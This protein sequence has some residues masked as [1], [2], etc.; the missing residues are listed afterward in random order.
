MTDDADNTD[1]GGSGDTNELDRLRAENARLK[2]AL[3][4]SPK[5]DAEAQAAKARKRRRLG[6]ISF[7]V[8]LAL[9]LPPAVA[10]VWVRNRLLNTDIYVETV[11]PLAND[12][13]IQDAVA[14]R[15]ATE[16]SKAIDLKSVTQ[17]LLPEEAA[18][19]AGVIA[20]GGDNLI[21]DLSHKAVESDQFAEIWA[22]A[23]R[24]AHDALVPLLTGGEG[25]VA[26]F[27]DGKVVVELDKL[28]D[29]V[30]S[31]IDDATGLDLKSKVPAD[32]V[33]G[34]F[35]LFESKDLA[36]L[37]S[38]VK[39]FDTISWIAVALV[40]VSLGGAIFVAEQRRL[41]VR[42][43]AIGITVS[44]VVSLALFALARQ[45][46]LNALDG[47]VLNMAAAGSAYD[48]ITV[49]LKQSLRTGLAL[50]LV[51]LVGAW[52]VGPSAAAVRVRGWGQ[53]LVGAVDQRTGERDLG[54]VPR[55]VKQHEG[56]LTWSAVAIG[57]IA[58]VLWTNPSGAVVLG[59]T[60]VVA[61]TVGL[62]RLVSAVSRPDALAGASASDDGSASAGE[63]AGTAAAASVVTG[64][65]ADLEDDDVQDS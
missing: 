21:N 9:L 16:A 63:S 37:Q 8:A 48:I 64:T 51:L 10:T 62:I 43:A 26:N 49:F 65:V 44:M 53:V 30:L 4:T 50:G 45:S 13:D 11:A 35:V 31:G 34:E 23:N 12:P 19:L 1:P 3:E 60:A 55:W 29:T 59:I 52:L 22:S 40:F 58:F 5:E 6:S 42:R 41:G 33:S 32:A 39:L 14:N 24:R 17:E 2:A 46:Y 47:V 36:D 56:A 38:T 27:S 57:G 7:A 61:A 15:V 25:N 18:P 20:A 28:V 54:P